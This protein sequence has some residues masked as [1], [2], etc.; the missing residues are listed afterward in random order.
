MIY[1]KSEK[2]HEGHLRVILQVLRDHQLCA[3][4]RKCEFW[5]TKVK[6]L[7]HVVSASGV[8]VDPEKVEAV[9]SLQ[10]C[11]PWN[12][13]G[14]LEGTLSTTHSPKMVNNNNHAHTPISCDI[15][16]HMKCN[17]AISCLCHVTHIYIYGCYMDNFIHALHPCIIW[18]IISINI[19]FPIKSHKS[20][21]HTHTHIH[22]LHMSIH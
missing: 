1:S 22:T 9:M 19:Q 13:I 20:C 15:L 7:G 5:H 3:K 18:T 21:Q 6:F 16:V 11:K 2:E 17:Y 8:S 4:F 10:S 14:R 12:S